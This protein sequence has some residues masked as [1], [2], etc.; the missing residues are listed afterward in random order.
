MRIWGI[1]GSGSFGDYWRAAFKKFNLGC[2]EVT[3]FKGGV[4]LE[5]RC[6]I[7][8]IQYTKLDQLL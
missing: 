4:L 1:R 7:E 5:G 6:P 2:L 8:E 3:I